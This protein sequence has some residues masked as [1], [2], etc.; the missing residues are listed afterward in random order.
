[1]KKSLIPFEQFKI[2]R[3]KNGAGVTAEIAIEP[4]DAKLDDEDFEWRLSS[5]RI[6]GENTFSKFPGYDRLLTVLSGPGLLLNSEELGPFEMYSFPGEEIIECSLIEGPVEDL[7]IIFKR[8]RYRC[9]MKILIVE[10]S[11]SLKVEG[12]V[13]FFM[14]LAQEVQIFGETLQAPD[15]LRI[16][17]AQDIEISSQGT[18]AHLIWISI[19]PTLSH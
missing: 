2:M 7:G 5:A 8:S 9:S 15:F 16:D 1:M 13:Q 4:A 12:G 3:W 18:T 19:H 14:P 10:N 6:E 11:K 17:D